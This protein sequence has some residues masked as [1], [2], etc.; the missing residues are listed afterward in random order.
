MDEDKTSI[1]VPGKDGYI[2]LVST[3]DEYDVSAP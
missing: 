3:D 1:I 2:Y